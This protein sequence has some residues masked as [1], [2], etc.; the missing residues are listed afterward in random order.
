[1]TAFDPYTIVERLGENFDVLGA[2]EV[3]GPP[4]RAWEVR[5]RPHDRERAEAVRLEPRHLLTEGRFAGACLNQAGFLARVR[6]A[7]RGGN[8]G[9]FVNALLDLARAGRREVGDG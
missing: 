1:M 5:L 7:Y 4:P 8:W 6:P 3:A 2:S 9:H